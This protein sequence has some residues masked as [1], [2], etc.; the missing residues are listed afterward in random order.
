MMPPEQRAII[1]HDLQLYL[2]YIY[3]RYLSQALSFLSPVQRPPFSAEKGHFHPGFFSLTAVTFCHG[4]HA[5][6][7]LAS[8]A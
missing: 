3:D 2:F 1:R 8:C 7:G 5:Y 4:L 6:G